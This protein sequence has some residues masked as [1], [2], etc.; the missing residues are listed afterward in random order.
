MHQARTAA[1]DAGNGKML[2]PVNPL[3]ILLA[4]D[5]ECTRLVVKQLLK[6]SGFT[7]DTLCP[8]AI[9]SGL[10]CCPVLV[11]RSLPHEEG[12]G[13][14]MADTCD[15]GV[16]VT[17]AKDGQEALDTLQAGKGVDLILTDVVMPQ[18]ARHP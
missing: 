3:H 11:M 7:G 12:R 6:R 16:A 10:R 13:L 5:D 17:T 1:W 4:E 2:Q 18:V 15:D 8:L 9:F 14:P